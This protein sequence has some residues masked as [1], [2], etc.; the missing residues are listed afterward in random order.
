M[1]ASANLPKTFWGEAVNTAAYLINR[2]PSSALDFKTPQEVWTG[3]PPCLNH[4]KVFGCA[5]YAHMRQDKLE[6]RAKKCLFLGYPKG[7]KA[8]RLWSLEPGDQKCFVSQDVTFNEEVMPWKNTQ[9]TDKKKETDSFELSC[10]PPAVLML[11]HILLMNLLKIKGKGVT[12]K[13]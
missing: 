4:L 2:S 5:A 11:L 9:T 3:K 8:F 7:I 1:L 6:P 13:M 12:M 10:K